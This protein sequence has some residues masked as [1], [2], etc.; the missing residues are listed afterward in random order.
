MFVCCR[1]LEEKRPE[2]PRG[3]VRGMAP[4]RHPTVTRTFKSS[5]KKGK[6]EIFNIY[7]C[8]LEDCFFLANVV[9]I[10]S[11]RQKF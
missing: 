4:S 9:K 5:I 1:R 3:T 8:F 11:G 10:E 7:I 6:Y 2:I